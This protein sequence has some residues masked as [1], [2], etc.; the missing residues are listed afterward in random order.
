MRD[1][2]LKRQ[3]VRSFKKVSRK[4]ITLSHDT[5]VQVQPLREGQSLPLLVQPSVKGIKLLAW[6]QQNRE[7]IQTKV[8]HY[9]AL[10][11]RDFSIAGVTEFQQ[12]VKAVSGGALEYRF[13]ASPRTEVGKHVYTATNYPAD[14]S[15]FPHNEHAFSPIFPLHL[16]FFC[17]I[18]AQE[19][20]ETPIGDTRQL[21]RRIAPEVREQFL[22]K[23]IMYVRN[24]GDGFGLPWQTVFQTKDKA[25]VEAYCRRVGIDVE[26][27][28]GS[29]L[30]TRQVGPAIMRHPRTEEYVWFN[31]GTFFHVS[32]LEATIREALL[33][34]FSEEDLPQ[35]TYYGDGNPIES[36]VLEH[37]RAI[38]Q[39]AM[40]EFPW[41]QGDVVFLDNM[42][43]L[44]ARK[45]FVGNR[46]IL[47]AMAEAC[48]SEDLYLCQEEELGCQIQTL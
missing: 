43:A 11:F 44:H 36:H 20:G 13:R 18:P 5:L 41:Q 31:H 4:V 3:G 22:K 14:Q 10:L 27:K 9:G 33:K 46:R 32:T 30:R 1:L 24:Y 37:L 12:C 21:L 15:I 42:L 38:Y 25:E 39:Q 40:V 35:N 6:V 34:E 29:R 26:W 28:G 2:D 48:R 17:D 7:W 47:V 8:L 45:P 23:K 19:G 16:Y